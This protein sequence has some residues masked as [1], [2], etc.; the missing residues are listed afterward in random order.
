[1]F[2]LGTATKVGQKRA[3]YE[4]FQLIARK[5]GD[6]KRDGTEKVLP[7]CPLW[8]KSYVVVLADRFRL[9][10]KARN[11]GMPAKITSSP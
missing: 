8:W 6:K 11:T 4:E 1:M 7:L 3:I 2:L 5:S 9:A 10:A